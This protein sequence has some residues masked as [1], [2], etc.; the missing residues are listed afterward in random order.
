[1]RR[2]VF[3]F[4]VFISADLIGQQFPFELWHEGKLVL[5]TGDTLKG[6]IKY[7]LQTDL[8]Q[9]QE[10]NRNESYTARKVLF[11]EIFDQT[12]KYYRDFYSMPYNTSGQYKAPVFFELL[13]EGKI[14]LLCRE[15]VEYKTYSS[16]YYF[17]GGYTRRV[18]VYKYFLF[19][20]DGSIKEF[21]GKKNDWLELMGKNADDV[22]KYARINRLDFD[23]KSELAKIIEYYNSLYSNK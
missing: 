5:D 10:N 21:S 6:K 22:Q 18:L 13:K 3:I 16:P 11:F 12:V 15:A 19:G 7:N 8:I 2:V 9:I 1:M 4:L 20:E 17:S 14:T 23:N